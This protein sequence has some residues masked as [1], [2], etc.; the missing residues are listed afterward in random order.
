MKYVV[1]SF[2]SLFRLFAYVCEYAAVNV[3]YVAVDEVGC[4]GCKEYGR[5][6]QVFRSAPAGCRGLGDNEGIE[7]MTAAVGLSLAQRAMRGGA[8]M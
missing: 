8:V 2:H 5:T 4:G 7:W 1:L 3:E 6:H